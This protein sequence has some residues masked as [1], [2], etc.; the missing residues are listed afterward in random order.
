[1]K[2]NIV[3][4]PPI[5]QQLPERAGLLHVGDR[6]KPFKRINVDCKA[7][8]LIKWQDCEPFDHGK[9]EARNLGQTTGHFP[10]QNPCI[11]LRC[12]WTLFFTAQ[13]CMSHL[14]LPVFYVV[15][16]LY[17]APFVCSFSPPPTPLSPLFYPLSLP[18]PLSQ[19]V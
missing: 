13:Q 9:V 11:L 14:P 8:H 10:I 5:A 3:V 1:M 19:V 6:S 17:L 7:K 18:M 4:N 12:P 15:K 2:F 16:P